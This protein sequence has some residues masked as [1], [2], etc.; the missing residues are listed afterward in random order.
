MTR[1]DRICEGACVREL[2]CSANQNS[3]GYDVFA[4]FLLDIGARPWVCIK[5]AD[6]QNRHPDDIRTLGLGPTNSLVNRRW[7]EKAKKGVVDVV[8]CFGFSP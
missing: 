6:L 1:H 4:P 2:Y 3:Y 8:S 5:R 7:H